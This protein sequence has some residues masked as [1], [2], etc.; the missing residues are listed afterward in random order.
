MIPFALQRGSLSAKRWAYFC[1]LVTDILLFL[2]YT[3]ATNMKEV[4]I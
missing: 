1:D 4:P 3:K 2:G